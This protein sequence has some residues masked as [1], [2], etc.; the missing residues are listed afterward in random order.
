VRA[1]D[2]H[3]LAQLVSAA[4][5]VGEREGKCIAARGGARNASAGGGLRTRREGAPDARDREKKKGPDTHCDGYAEGPGNV[6]Y[7]LTLARHGRRVGSALAPARARDDP[8]AL[9]L[10]CAR[11]ARDDLALAATPLDEFHQPRLRNH[12]QRRQEH[13]QQTVDPDE[14]DVEA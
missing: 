2:A 1:G 3:F 7:E 4:N 13:P 14:A 10:A 9:L 5:R 12:E 8:P 6:L 11:L